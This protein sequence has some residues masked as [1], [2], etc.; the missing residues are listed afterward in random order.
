[1][2]HLTFNLFRDTPKESWG[3]RVQTTDDRQIVTN[4]QLSSPA[5]AAGL[6]NSDIILQVGKEKIN[7]HADVVHAMKI[8]KATVSISVERTNYGEMKVP[9]VY[10]SP[11]DLYS[12][13]T[14][15]EAL[16]ERFPNKT[17]EEIDNLA[18]SFCSGKDRSSVEDIIKNSPTLAMIQKPSCD[19]HHNPANSRVIQLL[20]ETLPIHHVQ[21]YNHNFIQPRTYSVS[22]RCNNGFRS[23]KGSH[24]P[25]EN[26][27]TMRIINDFARNLTQ[28]YDQNKDRNKV[29]KPV[30]A[31]WSEDRPDPIDNTLSMKM[32]RQNIE[33]ASK[34]NSGQP[35]SILQNNQGNED[36]RTWYN[37]NS[38]DIHLDPIENTR[39]MRALRKSIDELAVSSTIQPKTL[40]I[41]RAVPKLQKFDE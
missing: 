12:E 7:S 31:K 3:F 10:N 37:K 27:T 18:E 33:E 16:I 26:T 17:E 15:R 25:I 36:P 38:S 5:D 20:D 9:Q 8:A 1:M 2:K 30:K 23:V 39:T 14:I 40:N 35:L 41:T 24:Y 4:V 28:S 6:K 13:E 22:A 34:I 11:I 29:S 21:T 32:L 19:D